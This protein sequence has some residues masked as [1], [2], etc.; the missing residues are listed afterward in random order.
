MI[1]RIALYLVKMIQGN[2]LDQLKNAASAL[3][4]YIMS[5]N[6]KNRRKGVTG[7]AKG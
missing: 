6:W 1:S 5:N 7:K 3:C 2:F 4:R